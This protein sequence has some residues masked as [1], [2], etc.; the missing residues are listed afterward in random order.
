MSKSKTR[1]RRSKRAVSRG[2]I[3]PDHRGSPLC[4]A[5][6]AGN[7]AAA[8]ENLQSAGPDRRR[9]ATRAGLVTLLLELDAQDVTLR[10]ADI[11]DRV[12]DGVAPREG[13][14]LALTR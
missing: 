8:V 6:R 5:S 11:L 14:G 2:A 10:P 3:A 9:G 4:D 13:A 1:A 7:P 12:N